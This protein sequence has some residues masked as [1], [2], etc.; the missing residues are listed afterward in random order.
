MHLTKR[1]T[2][3]LAFK[4]TLVT[5]PVAA[6]AL[7]GSCLLTMFAE[8]MLPSDHLFDVEEH[9]WAALSAW[10][11]SPDKAGVE[12]RKGTGQ[13][14]YYDW[15]FEHE[16][17]VGHDVEYCPTKVELTM[18]TQGYVVIWGGPVAIVAAIA[19]CVIA[20]RALNRSRRTSA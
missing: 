6:I 9:N 14:F 20:I 17:V 2:V 12:I 10:Q 1:K 8:R 18:R 5:L 4:I 16:R 7:Y 13:T 15:Y 11:S 19:G 3:R